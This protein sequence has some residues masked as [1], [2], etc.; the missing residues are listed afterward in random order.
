M[1]N[2]KKEE[3]DEYFK[4][5]T[6][7]DEP[8]EKEE[9][10][11]FSSIAKIEAEMNR[12]LTLSEKMGKIV[13]ELKSI[14]IPSTQIDDM[15]VKIQTDE[16]ILNGLRSDYME[17]V[18]FERELVCFDNYMNE[19]ETFN[20]W[21][22]KL[23]DAERNEIEM[24]NKLSVAEKFCKIIEVS[25]SMAMSSIVDTIN[26]HLN[27]YTEKFFSDPLTAEIVSFKGLEEKPQIGIVVHYKGVEY[28]I[29]DLSGGE[30]ARLDIAFCLA[31]QSVIG[32]NLLM[33]DESFASLDSAATADI[34]EILKEEVDEGKIVICICHQVD[35]SLFDNVINL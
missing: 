30:Y 32:G 24:R 21:K 20:E 18:K 26:A 15:S 27:R 22:T 1:Y 14:K 25:E 28:D 6:S 29:K 3:I 7:I 19:V 5:H 13:Y 4:T 9:K 16:K 23:G 34:L 33:L 2:K 11:L 12:H 10:E 31:L 8:C 17:G 35:E